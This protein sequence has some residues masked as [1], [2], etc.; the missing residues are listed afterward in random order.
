MSNGNPTSPVNTDKWENVPEHYI[1]L[2][3]V[4]AI[5]KGGVLNQLSRMKIWKKKLQPLAVGSDGWLAHMKEIYD[6]HKTMME[7]EQERIIAG[8][9]WDTSPDQGEYQ[10]DLCNVTMEFTNAHYN[11]GMKLTE[12]SSEVIPDLP[13]VSGPLKESERKKLE[14]RQ[15]QLLKEFE[16]RKRDNAEILENLNSWVIIYEDALAD[17]FRKDISLAFQPCAIMDDRP[18]K[19]R[20][21]DNGNLDTHYGCHK[22]KKVCILSALKDL[23]NSPSARTI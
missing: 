8:I 17:Y 2:I 15:S 11:H 9:Q 19:R 5:Y 12:I 1:P 4:S 18:L 10:R 14:K 7:Y 22:D 23:G 3:P 21:N 6:H 13:T 20:A 16:Q